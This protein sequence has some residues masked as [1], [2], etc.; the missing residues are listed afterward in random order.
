MG[1]QHIMMLIHHEL[2]DSFV[3]L[4]QKPCEP[5]SLSLSNALWAVSKSLVSQSLSLLNALWAVSKR[6]RTLLANLSLLHVLWEIGSQGPCLARNVAATLYA[7]LPQ[8]MQRA[9]NLQTRTSPLVHFPS[10]TIV[11]RLISPTWTI[12]AKMTLL[13]EMNFWCLWELGLWGGKPRRMSMSHHYQCGLRMW[14]LLIWGDTSP[15][16]LQSPLLQN[17]MAF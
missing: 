14:L 15:W 1:F 7:A 9:G 8:V 4:G 2:C 3:S 13:Q 10:S 11:S 12:A 16:N 17:L 5:I 6:P